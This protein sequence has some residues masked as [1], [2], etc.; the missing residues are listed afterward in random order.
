MC[1]IKKFKESS[2]YT[3]YFDFFFDPRYL[4][5]LL[6]SG[7][8]RGFLTGWFESKADLAEQSAFVVLWRLS[9]PGLCFC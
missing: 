2:E 8:Q 4:Y 5:D 6:D 3:K 7:N 9:S 1:S